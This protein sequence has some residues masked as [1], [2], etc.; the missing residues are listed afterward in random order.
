MELIYLLLAIIP[1]LYIY[2][3]IRK[4]IDDGEAEYIILIRGIIYSLPLWAII[5]F[6]AHLKYPNMDL[7][8]A[9]EYMAIN[10]KY[11]AI[12]FPVVFGYSKLVIA[13]LR[14]I[15][16]KCY[17]KVSATSSIIM[18]KHAH[19]CRHDCVWDK[20][21]NEYM[22]E[23]RYLVGRLIKNGNVVAIGQIGGISPMRKEIGRDICFLYQDD[24]LRFF[25][26]NS[27]PLLD[28]VCNYVDL[29]NDYVLELYDGTK[30][31]TETDK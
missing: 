18:K 25:P 11:I 29:Q 28:N 12:S 7:L 31:F 8:N 16:N 23:Y 20:I 22:M 26:K 30:A 3:C 27:S 9:L 2:N 1:G 4:Q 5:A 21:R 10:Y 6:F 17:P 19:N 15:E 13:L 24:Y 14:W